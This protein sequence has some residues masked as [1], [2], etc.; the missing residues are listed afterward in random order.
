MDIA[1]AELPLHINDSAKATVSY[2]RQISND[3]RFAK[4]IVTWLIEDRRERHR[5][6]V[7]QTKNPILYKVND[8][9]MARVEVQSSAKNEV[10]GKLA[11]E[12]RGPFRII[13][14]HDNGSYTV[15]PF[16]KPDA[17]TRKFMAQD[18][19]ALPREILPCDDID[20]PDFRYL[21]NDFAPVKHPFKDAFNIESYNS[22][23]LDKSI[24][25]TKPSLQSICTDT[26]PNIDETAQPRP[27]TASP[28]AP[29]VSVSPSPPSCSTT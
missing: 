23:W 16:D 25:V 24:P 4:D 17:A 12:S 7:N 2:L 19:Y 20:L 29:L 5:E 10:V 3:S 27:T 26:L 22:M 21:N 6:R 18:L 11:I 8:M 9:V 28:T 13:T 14:D 1:M 15:Q